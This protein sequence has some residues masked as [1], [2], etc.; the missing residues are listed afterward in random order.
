MT[1][2]KRL[3]VNVGFSP[4]D[5]ERLRLAIAAAEERAGL[6]PG[7]LTPG[8]YCLQAVLAHLD[9]VQPMI[10]MARMAEITEDEP[11]KKPG[12]GKRS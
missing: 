5:A 10:A 11:A 7:T 6:R 9:L 8:A 4:A 3:Q 2:A 1:T 12:K